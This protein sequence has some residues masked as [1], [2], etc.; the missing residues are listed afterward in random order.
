LEEG[1]SELDAPRRLSAG[2]LAGITSV[3]CTY[4]LDIVRT[5][6]S[7]QSAN[8]SGKEINKKLPGIWQTMKSIYHTEGGIVALYRGLSPT[9]MVKYYFNSVLD[10][11]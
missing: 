7:V 2:A 6:L 8:L 9:L 11:I 1:K 5:R 4:P 3:S 10:M